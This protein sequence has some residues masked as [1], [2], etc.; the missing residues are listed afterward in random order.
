MLVRTNPQ[1]FDLRVAICSGFAGAYALVDEK[2]SPAL[3]GVAIATAIVPPLANTGLC[4]AVGA[5]SGGIGSFLLF[6][7]NFLSILLIGGCVFSAFKLTSRGEELDTKT[8][9]KR[10]GLAIVSFI[11]MG[12]FLSNSLYKIWVDQSRRDIIKTTLTRELKR[13]PSIDYH[14]SIYDDEE[15]KIYVIADVYSPRTV[16]PPLVSKLQD[17][18]EEQLGKPTELTVRTSLVHTV[19]ALDN[20]TQIVN[21]N[22]DGDFVDEN[23]DKLVLQT[24]QADTILRNQFSDLP[25]TEV[26]YVR[27]FKGEDHVGVV[28]SVEGL[29]VP[30]PEEIR[31]VEALLEEELEE[32]DIK[33]I[34]RFHKAELYSGDGLYQLDIS[35]LTDTKP[36][37]KSLFKSID[38]FIRTWFENIPDTTILSVNNGFVRGQFHCLVELSSIRVFSVNDVRRLESALNQATGKTI[39][40]YV[41]SKPEVLAS[42]KGYEPYNSFVERVLTVMRPIVRDELER[43]DVE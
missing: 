21:I 22:L 1:L 9:A 6:F 7:S 16:T 40:L 11:L 14:S 31:R 10:F 2:I 24:K 38:N 3:P 33:L 27:I 4:F 17:K 18:L 37:H 5:W 34:V 30:R 36:E 12:T 20:R 8:V 13:M 39:F 15:D 28:A 25:G 26:K 35:G 32:P 29:L 23:P 43:L 41:L 19:S 42:S